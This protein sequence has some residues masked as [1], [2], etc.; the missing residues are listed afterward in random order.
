VELRKASEIPGKVESP[1]SVSGG[2]WG[3]LLP[4]RIEDVFFSPRSTRPSR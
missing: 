1:R 3:E 4:E 2:G